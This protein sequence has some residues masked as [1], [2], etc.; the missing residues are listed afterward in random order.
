MSTATD[1]PVTTALRDV[2]AGARKAIEGL[3]YSDK[4]WVLRELKDWLRDHTC[5]GIAV[6][7]PA[8]F[9]D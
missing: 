5:G 9:D 8:V 2:K 1:N 7:R 3:E 6:P 4:V